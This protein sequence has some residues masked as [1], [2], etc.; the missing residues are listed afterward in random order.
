GCNVACGANTC[1]VLLGYGGNSDGL[2][3]S[4]TDPRGNVHTMDYWGDG[5]LKT[6]KNP[7]PNTLGT[8]LTRTYTGYAYDVVKTTPEQR[9]TTFT[10]SYFL[11]SVTDPEIQVH[12]P[13]ASRREV[14]DWGIT[15]QKY[16][17]T[18]RDGTT[19][20][21]L[22]FP[23]VVDTQNEAALESE[24]TTYTPDITGTS[25][26]WKT[27]VR[28][29]G[30]LSHQLSHTRTVTLSNANDPLTTTSITDTTVIDNDA[31]YPWTR[32]FDGTT[33]KWTT[34][35]PLGSKVEQSIDVR[36]R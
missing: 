26:I 15:A 19:K 1:C 16:F 27:I 32:A 20:N 5:R 25:S 6:D 31:T 11:G 3:R 10:N 34:T 18:Y 23:T 21:K 17:D 2:L 29:N 36:E 33:N 8:A 13:R 14:Y 12:G 22:V 28:K 24:E 4:Y 9:K 7:F 35:A 30:A